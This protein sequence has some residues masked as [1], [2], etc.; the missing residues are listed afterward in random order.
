[1]STRTRKKVVK[2]LK[3]VGSEAVHQKSELVSEDL[4]V[5]LHEVA[6][7]VCRAFAE[8]TLARAAALASAH[9]S[10]S[11]RYR[12][13]TQFTHPD[14][15]QLSGSSGLGGT[16]IPATL[17]LAFSISR[18]RSAGPASRDPNTT[19]ALASR[20][21]FSVFGSSSAGGGAGGVRVCCGMECK[22]LSSRS[23]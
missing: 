23:S 6:P 7:V 15:Q 17:V 22:G 12:S 16:I 21:S 3:W 13:H 19:R 2:R 9:S 4:V 10:S 11:S 8:R 1:M 20:S 14:M 5:V 18:R